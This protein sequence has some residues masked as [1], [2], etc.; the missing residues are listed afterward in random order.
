MAKREELNL[1]VSEEELVKL[2]LEFEENE[3]W[4][5][6]HYKD[7]QKKYADMMLAIKDKK[8]ISASPEIEELFN[9]LK[10]KNVDIDSVYITTIPPKGIA[11]IL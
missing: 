1:S 5:S 9:D 3:E 10:S 11:F 6:G 4:F 8:V 2:L 7:L